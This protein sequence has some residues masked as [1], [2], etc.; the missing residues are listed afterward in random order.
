MIDEKE[1]NKK[2]LWEAAKKIQECCKYH[3][4]DDPDDYGC[5]RC[6]F[7]IRIPGYYGCIFDK[8]DRKI[9]PIKDWFV[10]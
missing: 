4:C 7:Y 2:E 9:S 8:H 6:P 3:L 5:L 1:V 10:Y